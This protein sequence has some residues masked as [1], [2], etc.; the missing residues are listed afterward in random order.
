MRHIFLCAFFK[1]VAMKNQKREISTEFQS[2]NTLQLNKIPQYHPNM[3][4]E[5]GFNYGS[6]EIKSHSFSVSSPHF[7]AG[8]NI[9]FEPGA[10]GEDN[11]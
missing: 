11:E 9:I 10:P 4:N 8:E 1:L 3:G 7:L 6:V 2:E 5:S